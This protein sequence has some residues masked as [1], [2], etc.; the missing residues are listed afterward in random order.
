MLLMLSLFLF[1]TQLQYE[2]NHSLY[3]YRVFIKSSENR[4]F[5]LELC[6]GNTGCNN[7]SQNQ[8]PVLP[9]ARKTAIPCSQQREIRVRPYVVTA[10]REL[11]I[12]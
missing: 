1:L 7:R 4:C 9:I 6:T 2:G 3:K 5:F 11:K 12:G 8:A 10:S